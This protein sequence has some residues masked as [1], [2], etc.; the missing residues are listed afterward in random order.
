MRAHFFTQMFHTI[1]VCKL[2]KVLMQRS[3]IMHFGTLAPDYNSTSLNVLCHTFMVFFFTNS[4][5]GE[6][7]LLH[8]CTACWHFSLYYKNLI[9][10]NYLSK[11]RRS[12]TDVGKIELLLSCQDERCQLLCKGK[13]GNKLHFTLDPMMTA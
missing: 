2:I 7:Q 6:K 9:H 11:G 1:N 5:F 8:L 4:Y 10:F 12:S 13:R 3:L